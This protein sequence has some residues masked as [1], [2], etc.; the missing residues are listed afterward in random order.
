MKSVQLIKPEKGFILIVSQIF[1]AIKQRYEIFRRIITC[2]FN[3]CVL[4]YESKDVL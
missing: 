4:Q 2:I 3:L 1:L